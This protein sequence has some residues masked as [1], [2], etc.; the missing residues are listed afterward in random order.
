MRQSAAPY[1]LLLDTNQFT[2]H[3]EE[4]LAVSLGEE[5]STGTENKICK[6]GMVYA[7]PYG[8]TGAQIELKP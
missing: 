2:G 1:I 7:E 4:K 3:V 6:I 8:Q 5:E